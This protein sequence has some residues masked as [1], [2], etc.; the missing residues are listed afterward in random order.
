MKNINRM[1]LDEMNIEIE[2]LAKRANTRIRALEMSSDPETDFPLYQARVLSI[3]G[4]T[5]WAQGRPRFSR[6]KA[7][8]IASA[9]ARLKNVRKFLKMK[10]TTATGRKQIRNARFE[11][12]KDKYNFKGNESDYR[13]LISVLN[14]VE[15]FRDSQEIIDLA[16]VIIS[17][18]GK[19]P[20]GDL[21]LKYIEKN[22]VD[23]VTVYEE[24]TI[25]WSEYQI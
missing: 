15:Y 17:R 12:F 14:K 6:S 21:L 24:N 11:T 23:P 3:E 8:T 4:A 5:N 13:K 16:N 18:E 20:S 25:D 22:P 2:R 7:T 19:L 10:S 1:T 9:R